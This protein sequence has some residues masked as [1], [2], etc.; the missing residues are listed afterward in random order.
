MTNES[1]NID[2]LDALVTKEIYDEMKEFKEEIFFFG[3][4]I[5]IGFGVS[6]L[7]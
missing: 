2:Y 7:V 1:K 6:L 5:A 4:V 3:V